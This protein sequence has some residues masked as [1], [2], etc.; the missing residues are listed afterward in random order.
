MVI[1]PIL[2]KQCKGDMKNKPLEMSKSRVWDGLV[3]PI[4]IPT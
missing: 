3:F 1:Y 4:P 2:Y